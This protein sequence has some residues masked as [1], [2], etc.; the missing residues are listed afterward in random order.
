MHFERNNRTK[1][2]IDATTGSAEALNVT[3]SRDSKPK[4]V[5]FIALTTLYKIVMQVQQCATL[6]PIEDRF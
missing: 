3:R 5:V 4:T 1:K 2:R 6:D